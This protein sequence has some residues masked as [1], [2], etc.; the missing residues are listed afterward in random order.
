MIRHNDPIKSKV[1]DLS[2]GISHTDT[3]FTDVEIQLSGLL[4][5]TRKERSFI[6]RYPEDFTYDQ[7]LTEL[8]YSSDEKK[9]IM[10]ILNGRIVRKEETICEGPIFLT[11]PVGGG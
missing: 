7:M 8:G 1:K 9:F 4:R 10:V 5:K 2:S 6:T 3:E 11:L